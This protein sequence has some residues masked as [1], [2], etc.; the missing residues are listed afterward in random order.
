MTTF[1]KI[2]SLALMCMIASAPAFSYDEF[3]YVGDSN[4]DS[5]SVE[6]MDIDGVYR[7]RRSQADRLENARK[8]L[9]QRNEN[10]VRQKIEDA[11]I[12][13]EKKMT[14]KLQ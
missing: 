14:D 10:L 2:N 1:R 7:K 9:E 4:N 12:Q 11:R 6:Q 5:L 8:K 13:E 3:D